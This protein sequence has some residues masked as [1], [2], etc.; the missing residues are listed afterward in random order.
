MKI[1][2]DN[3]NNNNENENEDENEDENLDLAE[4]ESLPS[5]ETIDPR[6]QTLLKFFK[7][8]QSTCPSGSSHGTS[9]RPGARLTAETNGFAQPFSFQMNSPVGSMGVEDTRSPSSETT[10]TDMDIDMS[11]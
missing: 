11:D 9:Q 6:Q 3:N 10:G 5:P 1:N 2:D 7:P 8:T 4:Q